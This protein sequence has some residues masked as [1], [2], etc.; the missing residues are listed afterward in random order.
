VERGKAPFDAR[1][2]CGHDTCSTNR[3][4]RGTPERGMS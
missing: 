4:S 2:A 1:C 3:A